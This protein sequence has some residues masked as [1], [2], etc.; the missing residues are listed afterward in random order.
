M[1]KACMKQKPWLSDDEMEDYVENN[2]MKLFKN[3]KYK[4]EGFILNNSFIGKSSKA[5]KKM[6]KRSTK[7]T[8]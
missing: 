4:I 2:L 1:L 3:H 6:K 7:L 5:I 8:V